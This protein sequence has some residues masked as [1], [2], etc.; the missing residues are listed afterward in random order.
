M[1]YKQLLHHW[2]ELHSRPPE[3]NNEILN[4]IIW[5]N[6]F[7]L[8]DNKPL[9]KKQYIDKGL[10]KIKDLIDENGNIM[11]REEIENKYDVRMSIMFYNS[12]KTAIPIEWR[13]KITR[14]DMCSYK[15]IPHLHLKIKDKITE[16]K[17][18]T[19]CKQVYKEY[20]KRKTKGIYSNAQYKWEELYY[21]Y[22]FDWKQIYLLPYQVAR[23]TSI[24]SLQ[25]KIINRY[26]GCNENLSM[27]GK[28]E[29]VLCMKCNE[30]ETI[31]HMLYYCDSVRV[32][33]DMIMELFFK[34]YDIKFKLVVTDIIFGVINQSNDQVI[35]ILNFII[36][37][38]KE[39]I[40]S[41]HNENET[42]YF[43]TFI[44]KLKN[45]LKLEKYLLTE[46]GNEEIYDKKYARLLNYIENP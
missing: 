26:I 23:E 32:I 25:Y 16:L 41:C 22:D 29:N 42:I 39:Y 15:E 28:R 7:I 34:C 11:I 5:N 2:F 33:W 38:T 46:C 14:N 3:T 43:N 18:E 31:E 9:H 8:V 40:Y 10:K 19:T 35:S 4:E 12:L 13:K 17:G 36:L 6:R 20:I 27:W 24:Q 30:I 37:F 45:R 1:F 21:F 44:L